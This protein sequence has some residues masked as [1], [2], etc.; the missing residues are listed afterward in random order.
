MTG[1]HRDFPVD[2]RQ[3]IRACISCIYK[4]SFLLE[5]LKTYDR[6]LDLDRWFYIPVMQLS[7]FYLN[8]N[9]TKQADTYARENCG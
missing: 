3:T 7:E 2:G 4:F 8:F 6:R 5:V 9:T 1:N